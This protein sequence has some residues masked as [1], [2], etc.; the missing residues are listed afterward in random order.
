MIYCII[1]NLVKPDILGNH[2][3]ANLPPGPL[4]SVSRFTYNSIVLQLKVSVLVQ[5]PPS[6]LPLVIM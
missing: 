1:I 2:I 6:C 3:F 4:P 5:K